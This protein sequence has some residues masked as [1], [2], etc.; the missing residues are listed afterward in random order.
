MPQLVSATGQHANNEE[1]KAELLTGISFPDD[2]SYEAG[3]TLPSDPPEDRLDLWKT[4]DTARFL[5]SRSA[6]SAPGTDGLTYREL[7]LWFK[8]DPDGLTHLVNRLVSEG[9]PSELKMAKVVVT[10]VACHRK[11]KTTR[12]AGVFPCG[13]KAPPGRDASSKKVNSWKG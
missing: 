10:P 13:T 12:H 3:P 11:R 1:E 2:R 6:G 9:F 7:R 5:S 8:L 4:E